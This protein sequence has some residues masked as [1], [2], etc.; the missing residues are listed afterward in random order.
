MNN[1]LPL[2][3][4]ISLLCAFF[5]S[6]QTA[7]VKYMADSLP[8]LPMII[9]MQSLIALLFLLPFLFR[10]GFAHAQSVVQTKNVGLQLL[11]AFSSL[12]LSYLLFYSV[13]FI[14]LVNA[15]LLINTSPLIVPFIAYFFMSQRINHKLW[16]P[17]AMGFIGV[18]V[19]LQPDARIFNW[20]SLLDLIGAVCTA[21]SML[22][23]RKTSATDSSDTNTFYFLFFATL[24]SGAVA[25]LF[26]Q[27][28]TAD[29]WLPL[30]V[31]GGL[32]FLVQHATSYALKFANAQLVST[33]FYSNIIFA[34]I[35][36]QLLWHT[37]PSMATWLGVV[38]I[39]VGGI[40]C[41]RAEHSHNKKQF[42][43]QSDSNYVRQN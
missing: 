18:I 32:Y 26:W 31:I 39:V 21:V 10:K 15:M 34:A 41:I 27:P 17:I 7:L 22:I 11:R 33:L 24:I 42:R 13:K 19:V 43:L 6:T 30:L 16:L 2:G 4:L 12:S 20:A 8:P 5:Y 38:L 28:L 9:F 37:L 14:P 40:L 36:S 29:M 1:N 23:V 25:M 3:V 35:L